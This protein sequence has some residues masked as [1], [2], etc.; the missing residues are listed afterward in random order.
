MQQDQQQLSHTLICYLDVS[1]LFYTFATALIDF[2]SLY[3][4][5]YIINDII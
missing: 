4:T 3:P 5:L 1:R 2:A